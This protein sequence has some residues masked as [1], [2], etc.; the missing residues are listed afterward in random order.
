MLNFDRFPSHA[1]AEE[2]A[3]FTNGT[4]YDSQD[5]SD[6][7]DP[8]PFV[9]DPPIV[10]VGRDDDFDKEEAIRASVLK[11]GGVYAGT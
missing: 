8:F 3:R 7:V 9:L 2:F 11:F 4:V 1:L 10:L 6:R 5:A